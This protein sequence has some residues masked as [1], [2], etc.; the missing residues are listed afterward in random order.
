MTPTS[1]SGAHHT[2]SLAREDEAHRGDRYDPIDVHQFPEAGKSGAFS[3]TE[4]DVTDF[5]SDLKNSK[6][7]DKTEEVDK[8]ESTRDTGIA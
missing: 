1:P 8:D 3:A 2:L 5:V 7:A 6:Q 4:R